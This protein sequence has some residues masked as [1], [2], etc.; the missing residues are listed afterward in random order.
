MDR[1]RDQAHGTKQYFFRPCFI[2]LRGTV[3]RAIGGGQ[4]WKGLRSFEIGSDR[5][6]NLEVKL[7][8]GAEALE[9]GQQSHYFTYGRLSA[10]IY[11]TYRMP[12]PVKGK[13]CASKGRTAKGK[14]ETVQHLLVVMCGWDKQLKKFFGLRSFSPI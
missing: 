9:N 2:Y 12:G 6:E 3:L 8:P 14:E 11:G 7:F 1:C 4:F 10:C 13:I 5:T